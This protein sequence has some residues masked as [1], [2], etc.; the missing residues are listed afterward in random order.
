MDQSDM[1]GFEREREKDKGEEC[2][3]DSW[4]RTILKFVHWEILCTVC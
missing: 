1:G 3:Q 2:E 4:T